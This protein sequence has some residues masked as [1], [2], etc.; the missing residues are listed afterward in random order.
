[1]KAWLLALVL[2]AGC[3]QPRV[4]PD[5]EVRTSVEDDGQLPQSQVFEGVF[6]YEE[7]AMAICPFYVRGAYGGTTNPLRLDLGQAMGVDA[8][9][10]WTA[11][12]APFQDIVVVLAHDGADQSTEVVSATGKSP[13]TWHLDGPFDGYDHGGWIK[14]QGPHCPPDGSMPRVATEV[15]E[16]VRYRVNVTYDR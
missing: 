1:M 3:A 4:G 7:G 13:I 8:T 14:V 2:L 12:S 10:E 9:F 11:A 15:R 16:E 6:L 5:E